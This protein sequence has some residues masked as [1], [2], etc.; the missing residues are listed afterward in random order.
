MS[1]RIGVSVTGREARAALVVSGNVKWRD[2]ESFGDADTLTDALARLLARVP[3]PARRVHVSIAFGGEWVQLRRL[4][5]LPNVGSVRVLTQLVRENE[6]SFF[7]WK[8]APSI[9]AELDVRANGEVWGAAFDRRA[10]EC[11]EQAA[12]LSRIMVRRAIPSARLG[13]PS[14]DTD[15]D[16]LA[17]AAALAPRR[18]ALAWQLPPDPAHRLRRTRVGRA[19]IVAA[20]A[21]SLGIAILGPGVRADRAGRVAARAL[22]RYKVAADTLARTQIELQRV[23]RR[24]AR[25]DA[26]QLERGRVTRLL[27]A[28]S[29]A[30]PESTAMLT[31]RVDSVEGALTVI[32]PQMAE[33]LPTLDE[34]RGVFAPHIV[35][36]I[37]REAIGGA[38]VERASI[39]FRRSPA[40]GASA[41]RATR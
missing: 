11:V 3:R 26:F 30:T 4:G 41:R 15:A 17:V 10:I 23:S 7:L 1:K 37:T 29:E 19:G 39:R 2:A 36:S 18:L 8:G 25:I 28:L 20:F 35:G 32:A 22:A 16:V 14:E 40:R 13:S 6:R 5:G 34:L 38:Q 27:A 12:R 21:A 31:L 33:V 24:L 9:V